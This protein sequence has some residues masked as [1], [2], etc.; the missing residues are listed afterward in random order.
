MQTIL[1]FI[2]FALFHFFF[3]IIIITDSI[4]NCILN[5]T[6][7]F[8]LEILPHN[9][10]AMSVFIKYFKVK[11][12]MIQYLIDYLCIIDI[13][14]PYADAMNAKKTANRN[15]FYFCFFFSSNVM[16]LL[17]ET[18]NSV[19]RNHIT[20]KI[21]VQYEVRKKKYLNQHKVK[22]CQKSSP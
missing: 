10:C 18:L 11:C 2:L 7:D 19:N 20:F 21:K 12:V 1:I 13:L 3:V 6:Y 16:T 15:Q 4:S 5:A 22:A 17:N 14:V 9:I 8:K